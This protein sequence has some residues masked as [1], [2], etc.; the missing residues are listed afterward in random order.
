MSSKFV[1]P[2]QMDLW[3]SN[4]SHLYNTLEGE[5]LR[6]LMDALATGNLVS[7]EAWQLE[8][9]QMLHLY[10]A[11]V[12]ELLAGVSDVAEEDI[13]DYF[14]RTTKSAVEE[15][16]HYSTVKPNPMP[17]ALDDVMKGYLNQTWLD[18]TNNINQ[19]LITT[20]YG[21]GTA[22]QAYTEVLNKT[23]ALFNTGIFNFEEAL[24]KSVQDLAQAGIKSG[25]TDLGG[26]TWNME[27][28]ASTVLRSTLN[29]TYNKVK[30]DRMSEYGIHTVVV[31]AHMAAREACSK[32]QGHVVD[33]RPKSELPPNSKYKSIYDPFWEADYQTPGGHRGVNCTHQHIP[34]IPG[35]NVNNQ[36]KID[37]VENEEV[38]ENKDRQRQIE[39]N[40][41][42]YKK[43]AMVSEHLGSE[44]TGY[45]NGMVTKWETEME[46]HLSTKGEYL[47][48]NYVRETV[49]TP[50]ENL[51]ND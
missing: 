5:I 44:K 2:Y 35:V 12:V 27:R 30:T 33:L 48:R 34:F 3:S 8:K 10:N 9:L 14:E 24:E 31:T 32:I 37:E 40:I 19:T 36:P 28:Y 39:R 7:I 16:D 17:T 15:V 26:H 41:V 23:S 47:S 25:F 21:Y 18:I 46:N 38:R 22:T 49:Y 50:L 13:K 29:N 42:K 45:F 4:L 43:K 6:K 11:E 1:N 20:N 51:L